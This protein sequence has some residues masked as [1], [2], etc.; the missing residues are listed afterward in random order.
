[1]IVL[2]HPLDFGDLS[3]ITLEGDNPINFLDETMTVQEYLDTDFEET[4]I[5]E[6]NEDE[7]LSYQMGGMQ[8]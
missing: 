1:M 4:P 3:A 6:E 5:A 8:L 7:D 2:K